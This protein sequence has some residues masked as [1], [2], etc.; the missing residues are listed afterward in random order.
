[1]SK[2]RILSRTCVFNTAWFDVVAKSITGSTDPYYSLR[3]PDYVTILPLTPDHEIVLV[4]QYRPAVE[5][6]TLE[7]PSGHV[8]EGE[9]PAEAAVRELEEETQRRPGSLTAL[10]GPLVPDT[11]RLGNRQWCF[12]A[13]D[14]VDTRC[15]RPMDSDEEIEVILC[16]Q[17]ELHDHICAGRFNH[18]LHLA[19]LSLAAA[20]GHSILQPVTVGP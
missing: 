7:L 19:A 14:V 8:D 4:R 5:G 10:A 18:A 3:L 6:F 2:P 16:T 17:T 13:L 1:V 11:G 15:A 9:A 20:A 12:L